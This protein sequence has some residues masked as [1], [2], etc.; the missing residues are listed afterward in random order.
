MPDASHPL[1][2]L[3][4]DLLF[5]PVRENAQTLYVIEDP[6]RHLF[7]RIGR[8]EYI[9]ISHL[10]QGGSLDSLLDRVMTESGVALSPEQARTVFAWLASRQLL[11]TEDAR[12]LLSIVDLEDKL[13]GARRF[14]RLNLISFK[15]PLLNPDPVLLRCGWLA[16]LAGLP[17]FLLWLILGIAALTTLAPRWQEFTSQ[18]GGFLASDNLVRIWLIWFGLKLAHELFHALVCYRYGG[19]VF[20]AGMLFILFMPMTYVNAISS[21][22]FPSRWQR[23]HVAVA[24]IFIESGIA[25]AALLVWVGSPD[26][27]VGLVAHNTVLIAGVSSLLF[28]A[29]PLMRFD[30]YYVLSDLTGLPNLYQQGRA[31]V[32]SL[33]VR[34]FLGIGDNTPAPRP[35]IVLYGIALSFWRM[36]VL[37]SLTY[38]ASGLAGG[39]GIFL[40]IGAALVWLGLPLHTL[41]KRWPSYRQRN[42]ALVQRLVSHFGLTTLALTAA[43]GLIGW[44]K[45]I[46]APAVVEYKQQFRIRNQTSGFVREIRVADGEAVSTGQ[47]L[48]VLANN[49]LESSQRQ[50]HLQLDQLELK[51]RLAYSA[52]RIAEMQILREQ[53]ETVA[54]E[55][56]ATEEDVAALTVTAPGDGICLGDNLTALPGQYLARGTELFWIVSLQQKELVGMAAQD[57]IDAFRLLVGRS[58]SV[59]MQVSG[60]GSFAGRLDRIGAQMAITLANPA[61]GAINGG[62]LD[63]RQ[64][65]L[66]TQGPDMAQQVRY[67][68]FTP[69]FTLHVDI[70]ADIRRQL[71]A[72]QLAM[73]TARGDRVSLGQNL[74]QTACD[75]MRKKRQAR[76]NAEP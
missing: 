62:P 63:I 13:K 19:R 46:Q 39:L 42:P 47:V 53:A 66:G 70:P 61:L 25:F 33:L 6:V 67:E 43:M 45:R 72:G 52:G 18:A 22:R 40:T 59:D 24:G 75:W 48:V 73:L 21:W 9:L 7:F 76:Q 64:T 49:E 17:L 15:L 56:K 26:S 60:I 5:T 2:R 8:E 71:V 74:W 23:I 68:L 41:V 57:D 38:L 58:V 27:P 36:L 54:K 20:E 69:R 12:P 16:R 1:P 44:E 10:E 55:L 14:S 29:N 51:S 34:F 65:M 11:Q 37:I 31:A 35:F 3:R 4:D 32:S 28:N 50:L 30:G